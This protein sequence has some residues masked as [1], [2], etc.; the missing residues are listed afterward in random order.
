MIRI[1]AFVV[2][3]IVVA[4]AATWISEPPG[5]V[6]VAWGDYVVETSPGVLAAAIAVAAA[7]PLHAAAAGSG[8]ATAR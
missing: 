7:S 5:H 2:A 1:V 6:E 8:L 3:V 4:A